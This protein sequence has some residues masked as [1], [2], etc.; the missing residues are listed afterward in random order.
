MCV[1]VI[2]VEAIYMCACLCKSDY[3]L[4]LIGFQVREFRDE[5]DLI[6]MQIKEEGLEQPPLGGEYPGLILSCI[7]I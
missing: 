6:Q 1:F 3:F 5:G 7:T 2:V 4:L